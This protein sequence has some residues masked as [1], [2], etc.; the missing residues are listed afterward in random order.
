LQVAAAR[1]LTG[2]D[3]DAQP[4]QSN[5]HGISN[6]IH[7]QHCRSLAHQNYHKLLLLFLPPPPKVIGGYVFARVG[8]LYIMFVNNF[9]AGA[10]SSPIVTK[11][12]QSY[13]WPQRTRWLNFWWSTSKVKVGGA[14][15]RS[16][17]RPSSLFVFHRSYFRLGRIAKT[18]KSK[19]WRKLKE[20]QSEHK[21]I[22]T[23]LIICSAEPTMLTARHRHVLLPTMLTVMG[24]T[25]PVDHGAEPSRLTGC[26][27]ADGVG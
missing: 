27:W 10:N 3:S 17:E 15:M 8:M 5:S 22:T 21:P 24:S 6:N 26:Q 19:Y 14:G 1:L 18:R 2:S 25:G 7:Y 13:P 9:L 11:L 4:S 20:V 12:R 23:K 16:I